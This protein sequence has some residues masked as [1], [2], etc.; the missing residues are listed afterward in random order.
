MRLLCESTK[1][2]R[3]TRLCVAPLSG[4]GSLRRL[5]QL[6][7][8]EIGPSLGLSALDL[9]ASLTHLVIST[10]NLALLT[11]LTALRSLELHANTRKSLLKMAIYLQYRRVLILL[12]T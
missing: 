5:T 1:L 7:A 9:S 3:L 8:L 12:I 4:A 11:H 10:R 6:R 2:Q